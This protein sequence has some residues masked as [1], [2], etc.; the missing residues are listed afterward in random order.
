[1]Y[2]NEK[3]LSELRISVRG[4][5][6][7][8][9]YRHVAKVEN[10]AERLALLYAPEKKDKLRAAALLHD[11]TKEYTTEQHRNVCKK[12]GIE[13]TALM[14]SA[15]KTFHA[16]TA[17]ALIPE[18]YPEFAEKEIIGCVRWHTTARE[19][20]S[21]PEAIVYLAD[22]IDDSRTFEDCVALRH[23]FWDAEPEKMNGK[24]RIE[25]L[26]KTLIMSLDMTITALIA[27]GMTV[28]DDTFKARNFLI[29]EG[30]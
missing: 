30:L 28:S 21:I 6:S 1:M 24:D 14:E 25:H 29:S 10:M 7:E 8:K 2:I 9:R 27:D 3:T 15:P 22:Y 12:Y 19:G 20:I 16:V 26:R 23:F 5:M 18:L 4:G 17:A 11:I 13:I